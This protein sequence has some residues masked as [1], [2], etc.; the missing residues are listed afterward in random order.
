MSKHF[1]AVSII[2][3]TVTGVV[4]AAG[5]IAVLTIRSIDLTPKVLATAFLVLLGCVG[6]CLLL[7]FAPK[8]QAA[9]AGLAG[10]K[11]RFD[12][13][14]EARKGLAQLLGGI[15]FLATFYVT[16]NNFSI[17]RDKTYAEEFAKAV[18]QLSSKDIP[19]RIGGAYGLERLSRSSPNDYDNAIEILTETIRGDDQPDFETRVFAAPSVIPVANKDKGR[20]FR[21]LGRRAKVSTDIETG[22]RMNDADLRGVDGRNGHFEWAIFND[23]DLRTATFY[24]AYL[25]HAEFVDADASVFPVPDPELAER[26][27]G[28]I[29]Q[30]AKSPFN[31]VA[32]GFFTSQLRA[33][34]F[35][36]ADL[37]DAILSGGKFQGASFNQA[38]LQRTN[39]DGSELQRA[40][41]VDAD[42]TNAS[43]KRA[44]IE[45]AKFI[46]V[47]GLKGSTFQESIKDECTTIQ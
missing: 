7:W 30:S 15:A 2:A 43:F 20:I 21:I 1:G 6:I 9:R 44:H 3:G 34:T 39:F 14:N 31:C 18:E 47:K 17:E 12:S 33:V 46:N 13:E 11:D 4:L 26:N 23:S 35:T 32:P 37:S 16:W 27:K 5:S 41:F 19:E 40:T 10:P 25:A 42:L 24:R 45:G 36:S 8:L 28:Q 22:L 29:A 38:V